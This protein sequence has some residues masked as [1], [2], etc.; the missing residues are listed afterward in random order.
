MAFVR[1]LL[2]MTFTNEANFTCACLLVINEI[3][4]CRPDVKFSVF[5]YSQNSKPE[6]A[7]SNTVIADDSEDEVFLDADRLEEDAKRV[8]TTINKEIT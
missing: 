5:Q 1:R 2:Q 4:R 3:F 8:E 6:K 7:Q